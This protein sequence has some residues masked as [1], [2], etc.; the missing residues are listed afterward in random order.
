MRLGVGAIARLVV[1]STDPDVVVVV[2]DDESALMSMRECLKTVAGDV[3]IEVVAFRDPQGAIAYLE[4]H[5]AA[6]V[7][8]DERMP[9][10]A[11]HDLLLRARALH[12]DAALLM[13][14]AWGRE[15]RV[16]L[17]DQSLDVELLEKPI[18]PDHL[19][20]AVERAVQRHRI[21]HGELTV[22][23]EVVRRVDRAADL[24]D[25]AL[26]AVEEW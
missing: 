12:T 15:A 6:V 2:D 4:S 20:Y 23:D 24:A 10:M 19:V 18:D 5:A 25:Q 14:T 3:G 11:G 8:S 9:G 1:A 16:A 26:A 17:R 7:V 13:V 22:C 21:A